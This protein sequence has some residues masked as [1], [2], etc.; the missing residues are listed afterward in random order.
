[1]KRKIRLTESEL[2]NLI[3][4]IVIEVKKD[5][6]REIKE[7]REKRR[8]MNESRRR[9]PSLNSLRRRSNR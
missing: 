5:K 9:K 4:R 2:V 1:M 3:E 6:K 7:T 8:R